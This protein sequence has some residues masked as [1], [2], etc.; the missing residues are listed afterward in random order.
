AFV[1]P[2][3]SFRDDGRATRGSFEQSKTGSA[4]GA[5][6]VRMPQIQ[7]ETLT[8]VVLRMR[9]GCHVIDALYILR[10]DEIGWVLRSDYGE[11]LLRPAARRLVQQLFQRGLAIDTKRAHV[12]SIDI[13]A[14]PTRP[15]FVDGHTALES[16]PHPSPEP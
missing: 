5:L 8:P 6:R 1:K 12:T 3:P 7:S 13:P 15:R 11:A 14:H 2:S 10:P 4:I 9:A 16:P